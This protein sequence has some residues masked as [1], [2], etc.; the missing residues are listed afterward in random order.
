MKERPIIFSEAMIKAILDGRKTQTRRILKVQPTNENGL[1]KFAWG[2]G[3]NTKSM[4]VVDGHATASACPYG[5]VGDHLWVR[6]NFGTKIKNIGGT[7]HESLVYKADNPNE[8]N[9]YDCNGGEYPVKWKPSIHM[10]RHASRILLE[11]TSIRLETLRSISREDAMQEGL[12]QLPATRRY[13][14]NQGDQYFGLADRNPIT[15]FSWLW[16]SIHGEKSWE[17]DAWVWV[18][19]FRVIQGGRHEI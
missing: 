18:V 6:E 4:L 1:W 2:A 19:E 3:C 15:V 14:I 8:I 9:F 5:K 10:P 13:V 7:P 12:L 17:T 16:D 11:I